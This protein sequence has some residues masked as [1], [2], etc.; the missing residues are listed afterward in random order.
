MY[1]KAI[2]LNFKGNDSFKTKVG[3]L[4]SLML[5]SGILAYAIA[6]FVTLT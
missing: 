4:L 6:K 3:G 2:T 1:G 5:I